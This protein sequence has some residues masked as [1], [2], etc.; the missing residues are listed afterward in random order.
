MDL[1]LLFFSRRVAGRLADLGGAPQTKWG[2][3]R[4]QYLAYYLKGK[5]NGVFNRTKHT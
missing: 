2:Q 4:G 5:E 1:D 3:K